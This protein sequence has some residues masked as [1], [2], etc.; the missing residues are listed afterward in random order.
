MADLSTNVRYIKGIGE[1]KAK[2]LSHSL[3]EPAG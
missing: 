2:S 3:N 1:A